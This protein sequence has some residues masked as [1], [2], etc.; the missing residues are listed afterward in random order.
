MS[1]K[2]KNRNIPQLPRQL[3]RPEKFHSFADCV[4][5]L[6]TSVYMIVRGREHDNNG[7]NGMRWLTLGSGFVAGQYRMLSASHVFDDPNNTDPLAHHQDTDRYYLLKVDDLGRWHAA[8]RQLK[9]NE[10]LFL[11]PDRDLA[12]LYLD[13]GFYGVDGKMYHEKN[14]FIRISKDF[15]IIGTSVGIL[16]YPLSKLEFDDSDIN[17]P[18]L[19]NVLLRVDQGVINT[20]YRINEHRHQ[21]EFTMAFNPGNSGG[22]VFDAKTGR[23]ISIVHGFRVINMRLEEKD[24]PKAFQ[25]KQ[26][27]EKSYLEPLNASYSVGVAT[28]SFID[29]LGQHNITH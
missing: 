26:Y 11:Y 5:L 27:T 12:V 25:P 9:L 10:T 17:K 6:K 4:S 15:H 1:K 19:G 16:G 23:A 29:L 28:P 2:S 7:Q 24:L 20:R 22:P 18:R 3:K 8:I 13:E 21:Y 14:D